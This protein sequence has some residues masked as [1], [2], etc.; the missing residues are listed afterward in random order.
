MGN[1]GLR[2]ICKKISRILTVFNGKIYLQG[3]KSLVGGEE[4]WLD[5]RPGNRYWVSEWE[6]GKVYHAD[7]WG[8]SGYSHRWGLQ[9]E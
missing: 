8:D 2:G 1:P 9:G 3:I 4:V 5:Y 6:C 7:N